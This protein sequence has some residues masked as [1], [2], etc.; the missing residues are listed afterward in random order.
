MRE[1]LLE[2][3]WGPAPHGGRAAGGRNAVGRAWTVGCVLLLLAACGGDD[4]GGDDAGD[5][6]VPSESDGAVVPS[7]GGVARDGATRAPCDSPGALEA[8]AC[9]QCGTAQ[10]FCTT[11]GFW[12]YGPCEDETGTCAPGETRNAECGRCGHRSEV[13]T[14]R[15][16][17]EALGDCSDEGVCMPGDVVR[18]GDG[19]DEGQRDFECND[20]CELNATSA[21]AVDACESPGVT[22]EVSCGRCGIRSRFCTA[23]G[24][25]EYGPCM[26]QGVCMPGTMRDDTCGQCGT[27]RMRCNESCGWVSF[28]ACEDQGECLPGTTTR[29]GEGCPEGA[30]R[31]QACSETCSYEPAG[32]CE[33]GPVSG[34]C[35]DA[36]CE[37]GE[38]CSTVTRFPICRQTC[39]AETACVSGASCAAGE[40]A[41]NCDPWTDAGCPAAAKCDV[42]GFQDL[43]RLQAITVCSGVGTGSQ[44]AACIHNADCQRGHGC[45]HDEGASAGVCRQLCNAANVCPSGTACDSQ[46]SEFTG[47]CR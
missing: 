28:G 43:F 29:S 33:M 10:R 11:A 1:T 36:T 13:C 14:D 32:M 21:C 3:P 31:E 45:I 20:R 37:A 9:G 35:G 38:V 40:C 16:V 30:T 19:C 24:A 26:Q 47:W 12:E 46:F 22:E 4:M 6:T 25:W 27:Q 18:S 15:C 23:A 42:V 7:D 5:A 39:D 34:S 2:T 17:W 41:D 44:G 8:A